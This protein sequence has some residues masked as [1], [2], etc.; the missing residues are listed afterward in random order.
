MLGISQE[1]LTEK[2]NFYRNTG[3]SQCRQTGFKGRIGIF[4][5]FLPDDKARELITRKA[6]AHEL[7]E[8]ARQGGMK[9]MMEDSFQKILTGKTT[10]SEILR[11]TAE[12]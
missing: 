9:S 3:C 12:I 2:I 4:E 11:V 1:Q 6:A 10:L 7:T 5:L 8:V